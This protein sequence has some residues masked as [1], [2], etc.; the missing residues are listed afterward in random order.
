MTN[1]IP[2]EMAKVSTSFYLLAQASVAR[3]PTGQDE[4]CCTTLAK[5]VFG[6]ICFAGLLVVALVETVVRALFAIPGYFISLCCEEETA[7]EILAYTW[8]GAQLSLGSAYG[9]F[10]GLFKNIWTTILLPSAPEKLVTAMNTAAPLRGASVSALVPFSCVIEP[11]IMLASSPAEEAQI[12]G[13]EQAGE[14]R[15]Q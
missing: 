13:L 4:D 10:T 1:Q 3:N 6:E 14:C 12:R 15:V 8:I 9:A 2:C 11:M 5:R 7:K